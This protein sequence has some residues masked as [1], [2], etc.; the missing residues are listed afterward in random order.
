MRGSLRAA[1]LSSRWWRRASVSSSRKVLAPQGVACVE[2]SIWQA[3]ISVS[4]ESFYRGPDIGPIF[5]PRRWLFSKLLKS[6]ALPREA[7]QLNN[8]KGLQS[9][10]GKKLFIESQGFSE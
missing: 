1:W 3:E 4:V 10:L 7:W 8:Y 9:G 5:D 6:L 2:N